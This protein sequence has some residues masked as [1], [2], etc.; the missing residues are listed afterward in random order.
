MGSP[1]VVDPALPHLTGA[2]VLVPPATAAAPATAPD[3][4]P[5]PGPAIDEDND[6]PRGG[7]LLLMFSVPTPIAVVV[8]P[9]A[10]AA[11]APGARD[12]PVPPVVR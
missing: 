7:P 8:I 6:V 9:A 3:V 10:A 1:P 5:A 11:A 4:G 12:D 2:T